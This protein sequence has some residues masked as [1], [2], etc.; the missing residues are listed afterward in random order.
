MLRQYLAETYFNYTTAF[1][2]YVG[3]EILET[4][5]MTPAI[6]LVPIEPNNLPPSPAL[7]F[8]INIS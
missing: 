2:Q 5:K 8:I 4:D 7:D 3:E 6:S 1:R